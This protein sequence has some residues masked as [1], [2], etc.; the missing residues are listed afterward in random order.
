MEAHLSGDVGEQGL[1][2]DPKESV[3][4]SGDDRLDL[5]DE[6]VEEGLSVHSSETSCR[7]RLWGGDGSVTVCFPM[8]GICLWGAVFFIHRGV[9]GD[10][11]KGRSEGPCRQDVSMVD[12]E[13]DRS[14]AFQCM[15]VERKSKE[16]PRGRGVSGDW[17]KNVYNQD[18]GNIIFEIKIIALGDRHKLSCSIYRTTRLILPIQYIISGY[19]STRVCSL[20]GEGTVSWE[21]STHTAN[22]QTFRSGV[23]IGHRSSL[24]HFGLS[25]EGSE[26]AGWGHPYTVVLEFRPCLIFY[27]VIFIII[28]FILIT[29]LSITFT[30]LK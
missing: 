23:Q 15:V 12:S 9:R 10:E 29:N 19:R 7:S 26:P 5:G 24:V 20:P 16:P 14:F 8:C 30:V 28:I 27:L 22:G 18:M 17:K 3:G 21:T 25:C 4:L 1:A 6:K 2:F 11:D 13:W